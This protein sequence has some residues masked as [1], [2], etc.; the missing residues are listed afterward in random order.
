MIDNDKLRSRAQGLIDDAKIHLER[1]QTRWANNPADALEWSCHAFEYAAQNELGLQVLEYLKV[2]NITA[3]DV[4]D[5]LQKRV[6]Q[7]SKYVPSSSSATSNLITAHRS[8][9]IARFLENCRY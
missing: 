7:A 9:A 1:F 3:K 5:D 8:A 2:P 6:A 4:L